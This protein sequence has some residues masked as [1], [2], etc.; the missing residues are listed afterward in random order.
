MGATILFS[1]IL[2][3]AHIVTEIK[4]VA[5]DAILATPTGA[6]PNRKRVA[7]DRKSSFLFR[8]LLNFESNQI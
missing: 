7:N 8:N 1:A 6:T 3:M 5:N 2:V 4:S